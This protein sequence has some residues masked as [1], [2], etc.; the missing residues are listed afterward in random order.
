MKRVCGVAD[1]KKIE[2]NE[3]K[4]NKTKWKQNKE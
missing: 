1:K 4:L 2:L 3:Q